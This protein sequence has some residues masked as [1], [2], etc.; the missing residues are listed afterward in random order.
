MSNLEQDTQR[1]KNFMQRY[2]YKLEN[3]PEAEDDH[4]DC[5]FLCYN[6]TSYLLIKHLNNG[7][8]Y[9]FAGPNVIK[10]NSAVA[11]IQRVKRYLRQIGMV[12]K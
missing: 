1:V 11:F 10:A 2:G 4:C 6:N 7:I 3:K 12:T 9:T 8:W 5:G